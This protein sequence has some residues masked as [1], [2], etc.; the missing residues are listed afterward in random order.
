MQINKLRNSLNVI[1]IALSV[2]A[3]SCSN[4]FEE[5]TDFSENLPDQV[6]TETT[7]TYTV[8]GK[9]VSEIEADLIEQF[10]AD[11]TND[12]ELKLN[13]GF[14]AVFFD[15]I[16]NVSSQI[17]A[18]KGLWFK[19]KNIM[20][21]Y[22]NVVAFSVDGDTLFTEELTWDQDS[23][24]IYTTAP[25]KIKKPNA[26]IYGKGLVADQEFKSYTIT[27]ITGQVAIAK[28]EL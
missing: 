26:T 3:I 25:V 13:E 23:A 16:Q 1:A 2:V 28:D 4:N 7:I 20:E 11:S 14:K 22:G 27:S 19:S 9:L 21:A 5:I 6:S 24:I 12:A 10:A 18:D 17:T 15:S 8:N